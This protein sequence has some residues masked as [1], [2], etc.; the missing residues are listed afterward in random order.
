MELLEKFAA[1]EIKADSR[2][3]EQDRQYCEDHQAAYE[4]AL[5]GFRELIFFAADM[6]TAQ[7]ELLEPWKATD[8][9]HD[10]L[11]SPDGP[12]LSRDTIEAHI[13]YL[14]TDHVHML[15]RYF[16]E[17]YHIK[18]DQAEISKAVLPEDVEDQPDYIKAAGPDEQPQP[19]IIRYQAV[20]EQIILRLNGRS[21]YEQAF[22]E[23]YERCHSAAWSISKRTPKFET[24]KA[25]IRFL[26]NFCSYECGICESWKLKDQMRDILRGAA[27]FETG[28]YHTFP[29]GVPELLDG[30]SMTVDFIDW[31]GCEKIKGMKMFKNGRVDLK[32]ASG[33]LAGEF[34]RKYLGIL[35]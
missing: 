16:N 33:E 7:K 19:L 2:I 12:D 10:Y 29:H 34:V 32:F 24:A 6:R 23:L 17:T 31:P 22:C 4:S 13:Q 18:L 35:C 14:H 26:E 27:H 1:V 5:A 3:S 21:F 25:T 8:R 30:K 20:V 11:V 9:F 28:G 15:V